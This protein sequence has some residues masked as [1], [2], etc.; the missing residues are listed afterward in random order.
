MPTDSDKTTETCFWQP[1]YAGSSY[2]DTE[3]GKGFYVNDAPL[4]E[5]PDVKFCMFCGKAI[6][7]AEPM[8]DAKKL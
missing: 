1:E 2:H 6:E 8:Y 7:E 5:H 4:S 3:C